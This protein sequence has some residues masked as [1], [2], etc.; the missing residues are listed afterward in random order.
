MFARTKFRESNIAER[1]TIKYDD[2]FMV[3]AVSKKNT[4]TRPMVDLTSKKPS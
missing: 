1:V 4:K 2:I 3:L